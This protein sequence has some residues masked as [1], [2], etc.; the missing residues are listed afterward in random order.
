MFVCL[1]LRSSVISLIYFK[2]LVLS[3]CKT[4]KNIYLRYIECIELSS[5][6]KLHPAGAAVIGGPGV[7]GTVRGGLALR[8][9][10]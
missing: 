5:Q 10:L 3:Y 4:I 2:Q 8:P 6:P 1:T 7:V 9:A